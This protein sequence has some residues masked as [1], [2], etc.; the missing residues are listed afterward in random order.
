MGKYDN[1]FKNMSNNGII[2]HN[3]R[4]EQ[5]RKFIRVFLIPHQATKFLHTHNC[6]DIKK[7]IESFLGFEI[8][9]RDFLIIMLEEDFPI[10]PSSNPE[11]IGYYKLKPTIHNKLSWILES[12]KTNKTSISLKSKN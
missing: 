8:G 3:S 2:T 11:I 9:L 4:K 12:L 5:L 6:I 10:K 7:M 1:V